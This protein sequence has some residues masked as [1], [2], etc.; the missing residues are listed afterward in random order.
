MYLTTK[1]ESLIAIYTWSY[2]YILE[3]FHNTDKLVLPF[4][5]CPTIGLASKPTGELSA[6]KNSFVYRHR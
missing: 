1:T 6:L 5:A 4:M 2:T 3:A